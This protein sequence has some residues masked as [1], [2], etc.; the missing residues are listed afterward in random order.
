MFSNN[1]STSLPLPN[2]TWNVQFKQQKRSCLKY[3]ILKCYCCLKDIFKLLSSPKTLWGFFQ[4]FT[5]YYF[6]SL[7]EDRKATRSWKYTV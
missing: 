6:K 7:F 2:F 4:T 5:T 3:F 1:I